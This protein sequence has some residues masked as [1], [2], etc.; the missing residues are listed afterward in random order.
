MNIGI[1]GSGHIGGNLARLWG[2]AGH[3]IYFSFSH[4]QEKLEHLAEEIGNESK[5]VTPYDAAYC[6]EVTLFAPPWR[7]IDDA[8]KQIGKFNGKVVI[9][10]TNPYI[11]DKF[12]VQTFD[13]KD[14]ASETNAR[15]MEYARVVKAFNTLHAPTLLERT[16]LG[17]AIFYA[18]NDPTAKKL[19]A[20]LIED[21]GF[22]PVDA[23]PLHEGRK[24]EPNTD[25]YN[26]EL[27]R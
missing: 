5:A 6:S 4:D 23:G 21:A 11:D 12:N 15:K 7:A 16:G 26:V 24:Q 18:G 1:I 2:R 22:V 9:D 19:V 10:T 3:K 25:R 27:T 20:G 8:L 17:L 14:S 13:E